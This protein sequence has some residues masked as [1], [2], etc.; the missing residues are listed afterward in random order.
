MVA[1]Y[2]TLPGGLRLYLHEIKWIGEVMP[3][4]FDKR[5]FFYIRTGTGS[6]YVVAYS[7]QFEAVAVQAALKGRCKTYTRK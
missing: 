3:N 7:T 5:Y 2:F 1:N 6:Q 4:V